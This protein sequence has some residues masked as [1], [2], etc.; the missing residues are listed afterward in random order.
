MTETAEGS[1]AIDAGNN[2]GG[3]AFDQRGEGFARVGGGRADIGAYESAAGDRIFAD[4]F[5]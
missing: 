2:Y 1:P 3:F 4:G 5:D